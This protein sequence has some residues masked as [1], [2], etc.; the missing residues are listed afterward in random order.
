MNIE[1]HPSSYMDPRGTL[2]TKDGNFYRGL[3]DEGERDLLK[4]VRAPKF[5]SLQQQN[6][7]VKTEIA[8]L[9]GL[10]FSTVLQH[11]KVERTSYCFEWPAE[12][13]KDAALLT[14]ELAQEFLEEGYTL[15]DAYPWNVLF[16]GTRPVFVDVGSFAP[17]NPK[18]LWL[19]YQQ[20]M[21]FFYHP[22]L[23]FRVG[24]GKVARL[25]L[26]DYLTGVPAS[27]VRRHLSL[28]EKWGS[29]GYWTRV[30][31]PDRLSEFF[32]KKSREQK[33]RSQVESSGRSFSHTVRSGFLRGLA[34]T[35]E[36]IHLPKPRSDWTSYY[37]ETEQDVLQ[38]KKAKFEEILKRTN[39]TSVI[40]V[41]ANAGEFSIIAARAGAE[42]I[43]FDQ[44]EESV[45][46]IYQR[47]RK[48]NLNILPLVLDI[49][50][51]TP[52]FGWCG[53]QF[54]SSELR[55]KSDL[56]C[57]FAVIHHLVFTGGQNFERVIRSVQKFQKKWAIYEF[58]DRTDPMAERLRS[59]IGFNDEWYTREN[60]ETSLASHY[61]EVESIGNISQTRSL[62]LCS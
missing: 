21:Q 42:V 11:D 15:S 43:A 19:A 33:L 57:L 59:R 29:P 39:P 36:K 31:I 38:I 50:N 6:K 10:K 5:I 51:P 55:L 46:L 26:H 8:E 32:K 14:L 62:Y 41:G 23:L 17:A 58:V 9:S 49:L 48:E 27:F 44:D 45:S 7:V 22:L 52:N 13:L 3:T 54:H 18:Y 47:A 40:D 12:M 2:F 20:F 28:S 37:D 53:E 56:V 4:L 61:K 16:R 24:E 1:I 35:I 25:F 30:D 34:K 60:F